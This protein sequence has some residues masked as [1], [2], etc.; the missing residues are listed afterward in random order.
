MALSCSPSSL[1][2]AAK[3]LSCIPKSERRHVRAYL[4]CHWAAGSGGGGSIPGTPTGFAWAMTHLSAV[5]SWNVPPTGVTATE[6]WLSTDG[7]TYVLA[8]TIPAPGSVSSQ[9]FM[10]ANPYYAKIRWVNGALNGPFTA[11]LS[12]TF[13]AYWSAR[14]VANGGAAPAA[15][16]V[17]AV[18]ALAVGFI[19]DG[20]MNK[21]VYTLGFT[22]DNLI[23]ALTPIFF[24]TGNDPATNVNFVL[25]DLTV[26]GLFGDGATKYLKLGFSVADLINEF[27]APTV[28]SEI[29]FAAYVSANNT[30]LWV[31]TGAATVLAGNDEWGALVYDNAGL[32]HYFCPYNGGA[33]DLIWVNPDGV[34]NTL[35]LFNRTSVNNANIWYGAA[36]PT[37][38]VTDA[39]N[40]GATVPTAREIYAFCMNNAGAPSFISGRRYSAMWWGGGLSDALA[41]LMG[42]RLRTFRTSIGGGNPG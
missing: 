27:V 5:A 2:A 3:C 13:G 24:A 9:N 12:V 37:K 26:N 41:P 29:S 42:P 19:A 39:V 4:L 33:N 20:I 36:G 22:N 1:I 14:V 30:G 32:T 8:E 28:Y 25:A 21:T 18:D 35:W 38:K 16:S 6:L 31:D 23:A 40:V 34:V 7:V 17:A 11:S 10:L 15:G